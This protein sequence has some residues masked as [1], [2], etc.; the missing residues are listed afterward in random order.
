MKKTILTISAAIA[1]CA[2]SISC[3]AKAREENKSTQ[4]EQ[5]AEDSV[6]ANVRSIPV[7]MKGEEVLDHIKKAH[8]GKVLLVDFW[9]TWCPPCRAAMVEVDS[10]KPEL[11]EKGAEFI[12]ITGETSPLGTW[13]EMIKSI[14]GVHY[15]LTQTQWESLC[16]TLQMPG[17]PAYAIINKDGST[18]WDNLTKGG[19]PGN[20]LVKNEMEVALTK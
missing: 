4:T 15:R 10:I 5:V 6:V 11:R 19:Y 12:Y 9:A 18:A 1:I 17:I 2:G 7:S 14:D 16:S 8:A 3:N 20:E 13:E